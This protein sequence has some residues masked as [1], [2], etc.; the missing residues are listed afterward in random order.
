MV[1][2]HRQSKMAPRRQQQQPQR[3]TMEIASG[4]V[5]SPPRHNLILQWPNRALGLPKRALGAKFSRLD[6]IMPSRSDTEIKQEQHSRQ[7]SAFSYSEAL[8]FSPAN[9]PILERL[10]HSFERLSSLRINNG[11]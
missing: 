10:H 2:E 9:L 8:A 1:R 4:A 7:A 6:S 11:C 5:Y 3:N